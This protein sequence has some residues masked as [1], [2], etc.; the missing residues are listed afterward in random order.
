MI[1]L[2]MLNQMNG[3]S[4]YSKNIF[5]LWGISFLLDITGFI[6]LLLPE[7]LSKIAFFDKN[8]VKPLEYN[9]YSK[10]FSA[11]Y[12][13]LII[14]FIIFFAFKLTNKFIIKGID[15]PKSKMIVVKF[16]M[17]A[18]VLPYLLF[19]PSTTVIKPN[20]NN[21]EDFKG[22]VIGDKDGI[23]TLMKYLSVSKYIDSYVVDN[24]TESYSINLYLKTIDVNYIQ[25][26]EMD[27]ATI[28]NLTKDVNVVN[29][30][31]DGKK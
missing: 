6:L 2:L 23:I 11:I 18:C 24:H 12:T 27:A 28:F 9:P 8:L 16:I 19:I 1:T 31:M 22:T 4:K 21:L 25:K 30:V 29:Y 13:I 15:V 20:K 10:I 3:F 7:F 26:F 5:K 14:I 17:I